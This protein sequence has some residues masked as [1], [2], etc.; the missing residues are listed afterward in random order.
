MGGV[1]SRASISTV[2]VRPLARALERAPG[3][4]AELF[5]AADL[6]PEMLAD[7]EARISPAQFCVAWAEALRS[8]GD[9]TLALRIAEATPP[10]AFGIVEY[11]CRSA[12]T[13]RD[14]LA[15]WCRYLRILDD[16][17]EVGLVDVGSQT[18]LRVITESEAPAPA[19]HELC[20]ALVVQVARATLARPL[21]IVEVRFTHRASE[22]QAA[23]HR[24]FFG[25]PV[26]F[27]APHTELVFDRDVL[28]A[29]LATADPNLLEIL[30]PA[31]EQKRARPSPQALLT[32]QVR[33]ALRA[34]LC[35]DDAQLDMVAK[36]LGLTGRSLQR[37]LRDEGTSFQMVR[38]EMR[39]ELADRYL[40]EGLSFAEISFLLGFSEP[41]AFFR[42]FK[43]WTGLTP[44]E[45][46]AIL[47]AKKP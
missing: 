30:L 27:G 19:S 7:A 20:F 31:A 32:D 33:R 15:Q 28:A 25:A 1:T 42:A 29:P 37:R 38:D 13:L 43:R 5:A 26:R 14:A 45:R 36:R 16:A 39:R 3:A 24:A 10:G 8:S 17:V 41:S 44:F 18:A 6:T 4:L 46:R 35:N 23:R 9:P 47:A 40:G 22:P 11:V 21:S 2:L 34:A 12:A